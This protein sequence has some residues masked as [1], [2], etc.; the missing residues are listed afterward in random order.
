[1]RKF[2]LIEILKKHIYFYYPIE[3]FI[4][5]VNYI[6][7]YII[8]Y[9]Y[10]KFYFL[11]ILIKINRLIFFL[12][13]LTLYFIISFYFHKFT[14]TKGLDLFPSLCIFNFLIT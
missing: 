13:L 10:L 4:I 6:K 3:I 9:F 11:K 14:S 8:L 5:H 1:M 2:N 7:T 12:H